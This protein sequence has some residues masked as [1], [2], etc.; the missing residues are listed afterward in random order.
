M[1]VRIF[2]FSMVIFVIYTANRLTLVLPSGMS[3]GKADG[4]RYI[5]F[6]PKFNVAYVVN[7]LSS[8]VSNSLPKF[9]ELVIML[10][11]TSLWTQHGR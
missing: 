10:L 4:P 8:T 6:H 11:L 5:D 1:T 3:T 7:E 9:S 2:L